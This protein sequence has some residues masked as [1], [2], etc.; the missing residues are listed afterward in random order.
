MANCRLADICN[1]GNF[2]L[3][4]TPLPE[5]LDRSAA[6]ADAH[7]Q[8]HG[9]SLKQRSDLAVPLGKTHF[10]AIDLLAGNKTERPRTNSE[11]FD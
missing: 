9:L 4:Q 5:V 2:E 6:P 7:G 8:L 10:V 1:S 11:T 3:V